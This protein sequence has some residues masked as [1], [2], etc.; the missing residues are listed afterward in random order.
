M[1]NDLSI[2]IYELFIG[3]LFFLTSN[4]RPNFEAIII[5]DS[6]KLEH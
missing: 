3:E 5:L 4:K 6:L 1:E 2:Q